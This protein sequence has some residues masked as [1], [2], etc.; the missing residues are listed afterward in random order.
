MRNK[1]IKNLL[2]LQAEVHIIIGISAA[3]LHVWDTPCLASE[4]QPVG[5]N[6]CFGVW[7]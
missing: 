6:F 3:F 7:Y 5:P 1:V 4:T 2:E